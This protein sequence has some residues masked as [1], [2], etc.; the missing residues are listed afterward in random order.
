M[1]ASA[2]MRPVQPERRRIPVRREFLDIHGNAQAAN[3]GAVDE[4]ADDQFDIPE[5][6]KDQRGIPQANRAAGGQQPAFAAQ[7][8][9]N[10]PQ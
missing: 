2:I 4:N 8:N 6:E 5:E 3:V 9:N 10:R 7:K 1:R